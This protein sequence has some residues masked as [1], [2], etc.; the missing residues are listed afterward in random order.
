M[1][2]FENKK[3]KL[4]N[5]LKIG[6]NPFEK[7][8][9]TGEIKEDLGLVP[10]RK[11]F[12]KKI[13]KIIQDQNNFILPIIGE[14]GIGKTHLFWAIKNKLLYHNSIYVSL[15]NVSRKFFYKL[16]SLY[17][18]ELGVEPLRSIT[19]TLCNKWGALEK[20]FG[21]F[22]IVDIAKIRENAYEDLADHFEDNV[23]LGDVINAI[24]A[25][26]LDPY[27]RLEA[28]SWLLG[29]LMDVGDLS[30]L[31]IMND[32]SFK[33]NA[34]TMLKI[35]IENSILESLLFI[36][37]FE[38]II[39][40]MKSEGEEEAIF[41]PSYLYGETESPESKAAQKILN[42]ILKLF[43]IKGMKLVVTLKSIN[44]L[45]EIKKF[46]LE[47][48]PE[49]LNYFLD[50]IIIPPL[51][52]EDIYDLYQKNMENFLR[53]INY[54]KFIDE[55]QESFFPLTKEILDAIYECSLGNPRKIIKYFI[56]I[57]NNIIYSEEKLDTL[58]KNYKEIC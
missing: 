21:F 6:L 26:Q 47:V 3:E 18:E 54:S 25:H 27:K 16:Y 45:E 56:E 13:T 33:Q 29:E 50:P 41:D 37:D 46:A 7:F 12:L 32:L 52:N 4:I 23:A 22:H 40:M 11:V 38:K 58:L 35:L 5:I 1:L 9:A 53:N 28:E 49:Y 57:F 43:E 19:N 42:R 20:K 17:I 2:L 36:D 48:D 8:V 34:F 39:S 55:F 51:N 24:T 31:N 30:R 14:I 44:A 15:E 10:S